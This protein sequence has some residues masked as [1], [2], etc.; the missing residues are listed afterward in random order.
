MKYLVIDAALS[1]TGI[2][3]YYGSISA[4]Y[5]GQ[6]MPAITVQKVPF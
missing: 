4:S 1:G 6:L 2:S 5:F 3:G